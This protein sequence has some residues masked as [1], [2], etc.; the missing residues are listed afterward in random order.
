M[1]LPVQSVNMM[2]VLLGTDYEAYEKCLELPSYRGLRVNTAKLEAEEFE[3]ISPFPCAQI[4]W[5]PNGYYI[6]RQAA[7][8][9]HPYY[10]AGLY[11]LQEPSAMTPAQ[12][13]PVRP[14]DRVLDLCAAPGGKATELGARLQGTGVLV[15]NDIS[16]SR[17][18]G[19]LKNLE[20]LGL[21]NICVTSE[22]PARLAE[23]FPEYFDKI[24]VDAP[25]SGEGMFRKDPSMRKSWEERGPKF[26]APLQREILEAAARMLRPGG[27]LLYSTCTFHPLENEGSIQA[28]LEAEPDFSVILPEPELTKAFWE[29]GFC[30]GRPELIPGGREELQNCFRL[31]PHRVKGEGHFLALLKKKGKE[32]GEDFFQSRISLETKKDTAEKRGKFP[33]KG[34]QGKAWEKG[35]DS[36]RQI[37]R[38]LI[39]LEPLEEFLSLLDESCPFAGLDLSPNGLS[40]QSPLGQGPDTSKC[41]YVLKLQGE[42][43]YALP[44]ELPGLGGLR[45]LRTGCYLGYLAKKRF[46]PSQALAM[47]LKEKDWPGRLALTASDPLVFRYLRGESPQLEEDLPD[48]WYLVCVDGFSLGWAKLVKGAFRNK[49]YPGWRWQGVGV[50]TGEES[51]ASG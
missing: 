7:A 24:L 15:A 5:I 46:E 21:P 49:Y 20:L 50:G 35:Q 32:T 37:C 39:S 2:K 1:E 42:Q 6:P 30:P 4:P 11:Y 33:K 22:T 31:Y 14:G 13:L 17:A 43:L 8:S 40:G 27:L 26:Y 19:L 34:R 41:P 36:R 51:N 18:R 48:G 16:S 23:Y 28:L 29:N 10:G 47:A 45:M 44:R 38:E 25:C 3:R 12:T 9:R